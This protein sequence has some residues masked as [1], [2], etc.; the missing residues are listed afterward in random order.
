[1]LNCRDEYPLDCANLISRV[2]RFQETIDDL[3]R[4]VE[5]LREKLL[6]QINPELS[7]EEKKKIHQVLIEVEDCFSKHKFDLGC[8]PASV[9]GFKIDLKGKPIP[10]CKPFR[11]SEKMKEAM[12]EIIKEFKANDII[13]NSSEGGGAPAF[14]V[15]K[16]NG[17]WRM[18]TSYIEL[19]KLIEKRQYPMPNI[20]DAINQL[21]G[22][23]YFTTLD[24]AQGYYQLEIPESERPKTSFVTEDATYQYKRLPMGLADAPSYFQEVINKVLGDLKYSCCFGYFDDIV[25]YGKTIDEMCINIKKVCAELRKYGFK[26][27]VEKL[28]AGVTEFVCLGHLVSGKTVRPDPKKVEK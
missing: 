19:N 15:P 9:T 8:V 2:E 16:P 20:D 3:P 11:G 24:L 12:R 7:E 10:K 13:E 26:N 18:V 4:E 22:N 28:K 14:V 25:I 6:N 17:T 23:K 21:K 5:N 27:R 1:M